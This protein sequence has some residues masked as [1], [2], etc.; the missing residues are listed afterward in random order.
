MIFVAPS[1]ADRWF[2]AL[3]E[4]PSPPF[5]DLDSTCTGGGCP[6]P[7]DLCGDM[8]AA[9]ANVLIQMREKRA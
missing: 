9:L 4:A 1:N 5:F 2:N 6:Q 8:G 3:P 7:T